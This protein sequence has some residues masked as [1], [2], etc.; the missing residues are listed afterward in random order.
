MSIL[1][2]VEQSIIETSPLAM[3]DDLQINA[4][5]PLPLTSKSPLPCSWVVFWGCLAAVYRSYSEECCGGTVEHSICTFQHGLCEECLL[6][7]SHYP[8]SGQFLPETTQGTEMSALFSCFTSFLQQCNAV[9]AWVM[10]TDM[11][12]CNMGVSINGSTPKW[13]VYEGKSNPI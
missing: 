9:A 8:S 3:I 12:I 1:G 2:P 13:L 5:K 7:G 4:S 6:G 11:Q 10:L